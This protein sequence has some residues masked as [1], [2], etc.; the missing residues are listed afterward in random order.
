M[1]RSIKK[2][3]TLFGALIGMGATLALV[4][5]LGVLAGAGAAASS[6]KAGEHLDAVDLGDAAG[7]READRERRRLDECD[8]FQLLLD[9]LQQEWE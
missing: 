3:W 9:A 2:R 7:G 4:I 8:Q 1:S 6:D 5:G